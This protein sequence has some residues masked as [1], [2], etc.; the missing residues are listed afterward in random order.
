MLDIIKQNRLTKKNK[1]YLHTDIDF[2]VINHI[3]NSEIVLN[4]NCSKTF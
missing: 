3:N 4:D 2:R 1:T